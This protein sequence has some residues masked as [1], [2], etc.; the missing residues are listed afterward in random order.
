MNYEMDELLP[1]VAELSEKYT[2]KES[3]SISYETA[4]QLMSAVVYCINQYCNNLCEGGNELT[5]GKRLSAKEAYRLGYENL[6]QKVKKTQAFYNE[7]ITYFCAYG[8]ENYQD[9]VTK[10]IPGFFR[11][12]DARFAPQET[13]ITMDYPTICPIINYSGI[14]AIKEYLEYISYE[15]K[16]MGALPQQYV[17]E[18]L[19]RFQS[20]YRKQFYNICSIILR[21]ILGHM[22][23]GKRLENINLEE[24]YERLRG[25]IQKHDTKW[26]ETIFSDFLKEL[27]REKYS[28]DN[29]LKNYLQA[30]LKNFSTEIYVAAQNDS[31]QKV[32]AL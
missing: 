27:I 32:V 26:I 24:D 10:A 19:Y 20:G 23:I 6:I 13:I 12:Y 21:H 22:L 28:D 9:T 18:V 17:Y 3:T 11:H 31:I 30:D 1:I 29:K 7:M 25:I 14:D 8:N 15:Q 2:S 16:F 5:G 4:R